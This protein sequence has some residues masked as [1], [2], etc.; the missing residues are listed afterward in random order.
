MSPTVVCLGDV[1]IDIDVAAGAN[2]NSTGYTSDTSGAA[3]GK[4]SAAATNRNNGSV[5]DVDHR[6]NGRAGSC[7]SPFPGHVG[8]EEVRERRKDEVA[9][10]VIGQAQ[11]TVVTLGD[12]NGD[13]EVGATEDGRNGVEDEGKD[14]VR[15]GVGDVD[16]EGIEVKDA[17]YTAK[18]EEVDVVEDGVIVVSDDDDGHEE[19]VTE[20]DKEVAVLEGKGAIFLKKADGTPSVD[21]SC[22]LNLEND[23]GVSVVVV[24]GLFAPENEVI[25]SGTDTAHGPF[26]C[27]EDRTV[28][29][30]NPDFL[31]SPAQDGASSVVILDDPFSDQRSGAV[32][33]EVG[34]AR[35]SEEEEATS[36]AIALPKRFSHVEI[37]SQEETG[38][39]PARVKTARRASGNVEDETASS[40]SSRKRVKHSHT[41]TEDVILFDSSAEDSDYEP[42]SITSPDESQDEEDWSETGDGD[43]DDFVVLSSGP[44]DLSIDNEE[45]IVGLDGL[46]DDILYQAPYEATATP[47]TSEEDGFL[48]DHAVVESNARRYWFF[49]TQPHCRIL[50]G[51]DVSLN[52]QQI[53]EAR[54]PQRWDGSPYPS[55]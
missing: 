51:V 9:P 3:A 42:S 47:E 28:P 45:L 37:Y 33:S 29:A 8:V 26:A 32:S 40:E 1:D 2:T 14:G 25:S 36:E 7:S 11:P 50:D 19:D 46:P 17:R 44:R 5:S 54:W 34:D 53:K 13:D 6:E 49:K 23:D 52:L 16:M 24:N 43:L 55:C 21:G 12:L 31:L 18:V 48:D 41:L 20:K 4:N 38:P 15:N 27:E 10:S 35:S 22:G 30:P 39:S